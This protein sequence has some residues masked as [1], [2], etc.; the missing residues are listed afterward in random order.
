M[1]KY[2]EKLAQLVR[3]RYHPSPKVYGTCDI[4]RLIVPNGVITR[5]LK[6]N[7]AG[8]QEKQLASRLAYERLQADKIAVDV[9]YVCMRGQ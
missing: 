8:E 4:L 7:V 1:G 5:H 2:H 6:V 3:N 9:R